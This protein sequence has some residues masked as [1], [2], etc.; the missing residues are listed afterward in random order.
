MVPQLPKGYLL[1]PCGYLAMLINVVAS[2]LYRWKGLV[3]LFS[4]GCFHGLLLMLLLEVVLGE[5]YN[6]QV[7][8]R[9]VPPSPA[10]E[11]QCLQQQDFSFKFW[12]VTRG[13][14]N[15]LYCFGSRFDFPICVCVLV[16][17]QTY[18]SIYHLYILSKNN[19]F[20]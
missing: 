11:A 14:S 9:S 3:L 10:C 1:H 5:V 12:E 19:V 18:K 16:C 4:I 8:C 7:I 2:R 20:M 13:N 15:S 6:F 17:I